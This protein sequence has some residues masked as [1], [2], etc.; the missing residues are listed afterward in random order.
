MKGTNMITTAER[1]YYAVAKRA[2][3]IRNDEPATI[4]TMSPGDSVRQGDLYLTCL[5]EAL[6]RTTGPWPGGRQLAPGASRGSRHVAAGVREVLIVDEA[7]A[8]AT[9][10]RLV[11]KTAGKRLFFGPLLR[12]P[13]GV[14]IEHPEHAH[15]TLPPG[16]YLVTYQRAWADEVRRQQD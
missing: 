9:L 8:A 7:T 10:A 3:A 14:T 16:N 6:P 2:E 11:P 15:R 1:A 13:D 5:D 12:A 4:A